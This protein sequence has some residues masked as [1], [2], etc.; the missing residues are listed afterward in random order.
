MPAEQNAM[1]ELEGVVSL[2]ELVQ[3]QTGAVVSRTIVKKA[4]TQ[5]RDWESFKLSTFSPARD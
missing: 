2:G 1:N 4:A 3:Y 5:K